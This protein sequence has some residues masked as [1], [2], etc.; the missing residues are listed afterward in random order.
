MREVLVVSE[1][2]LNGGAGCVHGPG[3]AKGWDAFEGKHH[4][5]AVSSRVPEKSSGHGDAFAFGRPGA[6][7]R[8]GLDAM[9][10]AKSQGRSA[11]CGSRPSAGEIKGLRVGSAGKGEEDEGGGE[12]IR[13]SFR[14]YGSRWLPHV[15]GGSVLPL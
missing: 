3:V 5:T 14:W 15:E 1:G 7:E 4:G 8:V 10:E 13:G 9:F 11:G 6:S 2:S 12:R